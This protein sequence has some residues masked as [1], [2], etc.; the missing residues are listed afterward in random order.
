VIGAGRNETLSTGVPNISLRPGSMLES[1]TSE[2]TPPAA[3]V[4]LP[5]T[6]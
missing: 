6:K 5:A 3:P 1:S 4:R 2:A